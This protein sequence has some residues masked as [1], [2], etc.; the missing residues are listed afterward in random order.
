MKCCAKRILPTALGGVLQE[1]AKSREEQY[2]LTS[3]ITLPLPSGFRPETLRPPLS[4]EFALSVDT[5]DV[6]IT[7][8]KLKFFYGYR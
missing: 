6:S 3:A 7:S 5:N 2:C 1:Q 8:P 4:V